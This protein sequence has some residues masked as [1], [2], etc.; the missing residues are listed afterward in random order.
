MLKIF[1]PHKNN[2]SY[3]K[4]ELRNYKILELNINK[5]DGNSS[6]CFKAEVSLP[7]M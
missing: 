7:W 3:S 5:E 2:I 4:S 1:K 6:L